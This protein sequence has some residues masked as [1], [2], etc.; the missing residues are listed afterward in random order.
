MDKSVISE[1]LKGLLKRD[2]ALCIVINGKWGVGKTY[3]WTK[4]VDQE[5]SSKNV[6]YISLFGQESTEKIRQQII[7]QISKK[8]KVI[9]G[10]RDKVRDI[11]ASWGVEDSDFK[12]GLSGS[13]LNLGMNFLEKKDF[14]DI[15]ICFDDFERL[16]EKLDVK[17]I[18]GLISE[19]K[20]QKNC[21]V[22][23]IFNG[24]K[25][26]KDNSLAIYKDKIIDYEFDYNPS[27]ES[28]F[29]LVK[30]DLQVFHAYAQDFFKKHSI[31]NIR[32]IKRVINALND[33]CFIKNS[34]GEYKDLEKDTINII[35]EIAYVNAD[36]NVDFKK[37][38]EYNNFKLLNDNKNIN[39]DYEEI[40]NYITFVQDP[41]NLLDKE[42]KQDNIISY[43]KTSLVNEEE[44]KALIKADIDRKNSSKIQAEL[45]SFVL[46]SRNDLQYSFDNYVKDIFSLLKQNS[47][48]LVERVSS[49]NF[50]FYIEELIKFNNENSQKYKDFAV[51]VL[52]KYLE[53]LVSSK[54]NF[55]FDIQ[56]ID[57]IK[58]FDSE[59]EEYYFKLKSLD[60][61]SI[62]DNKDG[63]LNLMLKPIEKGGCDSED[64][65]LLSKVSIDDLKKYLLEDYNFMWNSR[66]FIDRF[67]R[68]KNPTEFEKYGDNLIEAMRELQE[69]GNN[70]QKVKLDKILSQFK[71]IEQVEVGSN[72]K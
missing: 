20:E 71:N 48:N 7:L 56:R 46:R 59:L 11:K 58:K 1:R 19:L 50:L 68:P 62:I 44:F 61:K 54:S 29:E 12:I 40:L 49:D 27:P 55:S 25:I 35:M 34:F 6:A 45:Q 69:E 32:N 23:M 37:L 64:C 38:K 51:D 72:E 22:V 60:E 30:D 41:F 42:Y 5:L 14:K 10:I 4:F 9:S 43:V 70:D 15:I 36:Y 2:T 13:V 47:N 18:L 53:R 31:K 17:D 57:K 65:I 21:H 63:V 3:F 66:N 67:Y 16:S 26:C 8:T 28:S 24:D 33:Y 52:K 39:N